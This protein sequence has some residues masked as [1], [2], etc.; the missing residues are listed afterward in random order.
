[1]KTV[2]CTIPFTL[3]CSFDNLIV[4]M[5]CVDC[6]VNS[7]ISFFLPC[8]LHVHHYFPSASP[9]PISYPSFVLLPLCSTPPTFFF[10]L[11]WCV[12]VLHLQ[13]PTGPLIFNSLQQQQLPQFS[14]QQSQSATSSPQQQGETVRHT[15]SF[16]CM[17][18]RDAGCCKLC[19]IKSA[20]FELERVITY[21][22]N[23]NECIIL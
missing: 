23:N 12:C 21:M 20:V 3:L 4:V 8:C 5:V 6:F 2:A 1:M 18:I 19:W 10:C 15:V 9:L 11:C 7:P 14:P 13:I 22:S 17:L 16:E